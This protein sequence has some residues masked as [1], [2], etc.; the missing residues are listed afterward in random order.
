EPGCACPGDAA[1]GHDGLSADHDDHAAAY[2]ELVLE[3]VGNGGHRAGKEYG[4]VFGRAPARVGVA[5]LDLDVADLVAVKVLDAEGGD[6]AVD[7]DAGNLLRQSGQQG[8]LVARA[9]ADLEDAVT[10]RELQ[11]LGQ[12]GLDL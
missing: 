11:L 10:G 2:A 9:R 8:C 5:D 4:V 3:G 1:C 7:F 6:A 12:A